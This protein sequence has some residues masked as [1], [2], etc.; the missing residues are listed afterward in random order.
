MSIT[1]NLG[2]ILLGMVI[3][4]YLVKKYDIEGKVIRW[5]NKKR[6]NGYNRRR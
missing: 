4:M 3:G 1:V 2:D 5:M 6:S